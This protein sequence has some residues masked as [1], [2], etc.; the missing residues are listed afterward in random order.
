MSDFKRIYTAVELTEQE[1]IKHFGEEKIGT[2]EKR[3]ALPQQEKQQIL[4]FL[5]QRYNYW[6]RQTGETINIF[7]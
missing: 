2:K 5:I 1:A 7:V 4:N 3:M 6:V